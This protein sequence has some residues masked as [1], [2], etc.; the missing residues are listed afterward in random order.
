[1]TTAN[2]LIVED[3]GIV[4]L[5][6]ERSLRSMGYQIAGTASNKEEAI[7]KTRETK[8]SLVLMDIRLGDDMEG[9]KAAEIIHDQYDI[10]VVYLTGYS[11]EA[12]LQKAKITTPFGYILKP[13]DSKTLRTVVEMAIYHHA[14]E[15][16]LRESERQLHEAQVIAGLGSYTLEIATGMW[17]S[18]DV[19]DVIFGID[20]RYT[21]SVEGW[22]NIVHP[23]WRETMMHYFMQEVLDQKK[24]F[25]K[26]YQ[27]KRINDGAE[28]WVHGMGELECNSAG[29]PIRMY[30][31]IVDVTE[32]KH[33]EDEIRSL[34][35][36]L[37]R[38]VIERTAQLEAANKELEAFAYS[39]S[40]DLQAPLRAIDGFSKAFLDDYGKQLNDD[41]RELLGNVRKGA[42]RMH[43]LIEDLLSFSRLGRLPLY[44]QPID[45]NVIVRA[46]LDDLK[47][48]IAGRAI[49]FKIA[50]LPRCEADNSLM[51]QV[52][53]NLLSNAIKFTRG[54]S[55]AK[56]EIN[57]KQE[58]D[59]VVYFV[60][61][62]GVGFDMKNAD[63][64][65]GVFQRLHIDERF[66]GTGIGL[67]NVQ[68]IIHRHGGK[69]WVE[70]EINRGAVFYFSL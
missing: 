22:A 38:R 48:E 64:L 6:I 19:L 39:V 54:R 10:P 43:E 28:R 56:I 50:D 24:R 20:E 3:S 35:A 63:K 8:P 33:A 62:N 49:E 4:L 67:A 45:L 51:R 11:D 5:D 21:R 46:A 60:R 17:I 69:I 32:R 40:H 26:E 37:E 9:I 65:F 25:D 36:D 27:I 13:F 70:A 7:Q 55:P 18:S 31:S 66:E 16:K 44:K 34:N 52:Y 14:T 12:T 59:R 23:A 57:W 29:L 1:M 2:I 68:R 53:L 47:A 15:T 42:Q 58:G 61:D 30:G 41:G